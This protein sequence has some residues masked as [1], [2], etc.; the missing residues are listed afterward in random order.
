MTS[1]IPEIQVQFAQL[2]M[3]Q[4][5]IS[6]EQLR[7]SFELYRRYWA[8][9][10]ETPSLGRI[11]VA[12]RLLTL[13]K[14]EAILRH[15][16]KGEPMPPPAPQTIL[17][18]TP[19][20]L[21]DADFETG[22]DFGLEPPGSAVDL[23]V[24]ANPATTNERNALIQGLG[25]TVMHEEL[26]N[27]KG[28]RI[29]QVVGEGAMGT[30]YRAQQISMDRTVAL[31]VLP[32]EQTR[33]Q[34][35]VNEFLAEA[36]NAGRLN[37]PNLVRVHEVSEQGGTYFYSMEYVEGPQLDE[38][39]DDCEGGR[40]D[41][42]D[43]VNIFGQIAS[44]L[45]YGFRCGVIHREIRPNTIMICEDKQA[46][47]NDLGL[48]RDE[49]TRFL[50]GENAYYVAPEQ[51]IGGQVDTRADIY[52]LG[53]CMFHC[54]TGE[55][56]FE[57]GNPKEVLQQRL[58]CP[59]PNPR[60][61]NPDIPVD[62]ANVVMRM[63]ARDVKDRYQTPSEVAEAL[64]SIVLATATR[65]MHP[66]PVKFTQKRPLRRGSYGTGVRGKASNLRSG[67]RISQLRRKR[68]RP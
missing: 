41:V 51:I 46:K 29:M 8:A 20:S 43:V 45:D 53:C 5:F 18:N 66:L 61:L 2:V 44:A 52:S 16:M 36:R 68:Y 33:N 49:H 59:V 67:G 21:T 9:G 34:Q 4:R 32:A 63:M 7:S 64:K 25:A 50:D 57:G 24:N 27:I 15:I 19:Q 14:A 56:P 42:K 60:G 47:L 3:Q 6:P 38:W 10:G 62:L 23:P 13:P 26:K 48:T 35:F 22:E 65:G 54:L 40:L 58:T 30:V 17:Q 1:A 28:Y 31:K 55:P 11:L 12:R 39:M 37:H